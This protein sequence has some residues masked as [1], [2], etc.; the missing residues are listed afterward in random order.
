MCVHRSQLSSCIFDVLLCVIMPFCAVLQYLFH[1]YTCVQNLPLVPTFET[2][3][4]RQNVNSEHVLISPVSQ[5]SDFDF[6]F[7]S[8]LHGWCK[9][10]NSLTACTIYLFLCMLWIYYIYIKKKKIYI[11]IYCISV[12]ILLHLYIYIYNDATVPQARAASLSSPLSPWCL[13]HYLGLDLLGPTRPTTDHLWLSDGPLG[14]F[15]R[16]CFFL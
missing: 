15:L 12:K 1:H 7:A 3:L 11:Y 8:Q 5:R 10:R 13:D 9:G 14:L 2:K 16:L 4:Y 6:V